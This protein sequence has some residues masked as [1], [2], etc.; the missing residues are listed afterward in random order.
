VTI[1]NFTYYTEHCLKLKA[2][3]LW[4]S[5][6]KA[7]S[8]VIAD[9]SS[10]DYLG[11]SKNSQIIANSMKYC[12]TYGS[13]STGSRL[14]SGNLP[15]YEDL[16]Q[17]IALKKNTKTA[18]IFNSGYQAN[19]SIIATLLNK[20]IL[21]NEPLVFTDRLNHSSIHQGCFLAQVKQLRYR[22]LDMNHLEELLEQYKDSNQPKF[23]ISETVF[24]MDGDLV[25]MQAI[26]LLAKKHNAF[27]YLDEAHA[28]GLYGK[29]GYGL[30]CDFADIVDLTMGTFSKALGSFGC[31]I[32]CSKELKEYLIN[33]CPGF[34]YST[35]LP[36]MIIGAMKAAW[37]LIPNLD[38]TR[39]KIFDQS[40]AIR[41]K[42]Q[43]LGFETNSY[44]SN[45]IP[46][47]IGKE[48]ETLKYKSYLANHGI[49]VS[50]IRP[51]TVP[52]NTSRL[53]IAICAE[54]TSEQV[55][56]LISLLKEI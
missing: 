9:F 43:Q 24:G 47:I 46:I 21:K 39:K 6:P 22:H 28:T 54:H 48:E 11:L 40:A 10:N 23:I 7:K 29:E 19:S 27:L 56:L 25:D 42:I 12:Q 33:C 26:T 50:A 17:E 37:N 20:Q 34:I 53:R 31:Y 30:S 2:Q 32:A 52:P 14:L 38:Q 36:P 5:L 18:L 3:N 35:A 51:P 45:I 49:I 15:I 41:Q 44:P 1:H 55:D 13:G 8:D 16:E 4:R